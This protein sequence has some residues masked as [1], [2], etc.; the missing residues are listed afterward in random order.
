MIKT[1]DSRNSAHIHT[2]RL[3]T[4]VRK[5]VVQLQMETEQKGTPTYCEVSGYVAEGLW[6]GLRQWYEISLF[7]KAS[8]S[9]L[10]PTLPS[11]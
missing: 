6:L 11:V 10:R 7:S 2:D 1:D 8:T 3:H 4:Q 9:D 5:Y